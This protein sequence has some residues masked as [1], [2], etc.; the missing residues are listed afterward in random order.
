MSHGFYCR[1]CGHCETHHYN[2]YLVE[3]LGWDGNKPLEGYRVSLNKCPGFTYKWTDRK[4]A[5]KAREEDPVS[6][7]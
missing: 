1:N 2:A 4:D 3:E 7:S 5:E 6:I